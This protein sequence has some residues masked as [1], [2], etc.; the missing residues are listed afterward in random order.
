MVTIC[1]T[2]RNRSTAEIQPK[3]INGA[4]ILSCRIEEIQ[5]CSPVSR[6]QN[7]PLWREN[8]RKS[9]SAKP[10]PAS[11]MRKGKLWKQNCRSSN[12]KIAKPAICK[13]QNCG[14]NLAEQILRVQN[15]RILEVKVGEP[16]IQNPQICRRNLAEWILEDQNC[17]SSKVKVGEPT[18][19]NKKNCVKDLEE[20]ILWNPI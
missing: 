17:R 9:I 14:R 2:S 5:I 8:L 3:K 18:I 20:I 16:T 11:H 7:R 10:H 1:S 15:C 13:P 6:M 12:M 19:W 4:K